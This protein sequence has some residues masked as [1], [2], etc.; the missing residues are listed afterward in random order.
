M[1]HVRST[2]SQA[3]KWIQETEDQ[4]EEIRKKITTNDRRKRALLAS[5]NPRCRQI[6]PS[7]VRDCRELEDER[8][9]LNSE[10]IG[11]QR[12]LKQQEV[13]QM[14]EVVRSPEEIRTMMVP[15]VPTETRTPATIVLVSPG[16]FD[17]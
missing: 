12:L 1:T 6:N 5:Q 15:P 14:S 10:I 13:D 4:I 7:F 3:E 8:A 17:C 9:A 2:M 16:L 11:L